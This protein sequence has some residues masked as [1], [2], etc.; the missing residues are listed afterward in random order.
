MLKLTKM[1]RIILRLFIPWN[2]REMIQL[3]VYNLLQKLSVAA[4]S[5]TEMIKRL[6]KTT[7]RLCTI[8]WCKFIRAR[9][10]SGSLYY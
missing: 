9:Q 5:A 2:V 8:S 7:C 1:S 4:P 6:A 10:G 3:S